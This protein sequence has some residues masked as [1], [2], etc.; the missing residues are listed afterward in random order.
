MCSLWKRCWFR[1]VLKIPPLLHIVTQSVYEQLEKENTQLR[2]EVDM[3]RQQIAQLSSRLAS[4]T[5]LV[6]AILELNSPYQIQNH[7]A[8]LMCQEEEVS[9]HYQV[10]ACI[11]SVIQLFGQQ[12]V[13]NSCFSNR[14]KI[15]C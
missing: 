11:A 1:R 10:R 3:Q 14:K 4:V 6:C 12:T 2:K 15:P 8:T 9:H 13:I 5:K 7:L